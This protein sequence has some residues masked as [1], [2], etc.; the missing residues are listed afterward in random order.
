MGSDWRFALGLA[1]RVAVLLA[2]LIGVVA[3]FSTPGL[4]AVRLVAVLLA[5]AAT[6]WIWAYASRSA[7]ATARFIEALEAGDLAARTEERGGHFGTLARALNAAVARLRAE[8][9]RDRAATR[10]AEALLDDM[11]VALL[12]I[13]GGTVTPANKLARRLFRAELHGA[14]AAAF[15]AYGAT[16]AKRLA[17]PAAAG[18]ETLMLRLDERMQHAIVRFGSVDRLG[19]RV[20]VATVQP[21]QAAFDTIEMAAQT[22]LVR[23]LTHE[24]LNSLTPI[25]SLAETAAALLDALGPSD[26]PRLTDAALAVRTLARRTAGLGRFIESYRAVARPPEIVRQCFLARPW[27]DEL[28]RLLAPLSDGVAID[29]AATPEDAT[30]DADPDLL[31]QAV[32]NLAKNGL[33]AARGACGAPRVSIA[34]R[35]TASAA[36]I[37]VADTGGGVPEHLR[38]DVFLPFFTTRPGGTGIGLNLAR[39]I[40]IAH[41]GSIEIGNNRPHGAVFRISLPGQRPGARPSE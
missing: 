16:F 23:V 12:A 20:R 26:D 38:R 5:A 25:G 31:A 7:T 14:P 2:A 4:S 3:A 39:Q 6:M 1:L 37:E 19:G 13:D 18:E 24:I 11:P 22:D 33:A 27:L 21:V 9:D 17:D 29:C 40:A 35:A 28:M 32:I 10:Y 8:R 30:L 41:G 34:L 36:I 15:A